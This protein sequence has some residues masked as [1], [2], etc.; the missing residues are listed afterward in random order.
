MAGIKTLKVQIDLL[1][2]SVGSSSA[3]VTSGFKSLTSGIGKVVAGFHTLKRIATSA[4]RAMNDSIDFV[5]VSNLFDVAF[6]KNTKS[7]N[8]FYAQAMKF[9]NQ[10]HEAFGTN[11]AETMKYQALFNQMSKSMGMTN[12][13]AYLLSE[14]FT[15]LGFD[16]SSLYN[17][18]TDEAMR[19]LRAGL[20]GQTKPLRD[21]GLDITQQS[22][23]PLVTE[24][25]IDKTV[26]S[27]SQAEKMALRYI[28]VIR[29]ASASH[30]DFSRTINTP[31]NQLKMLSANFAELRR[32]I[33]NLAYGFSKTL[34]PIINAVV[35]VLKILIEQIG[36][37]AGFKMEDNAWGVENLADEF[38]DAT[39][40]AKKLKN[41]T[42]GIDE[43]NVVSSND[44]GT[45]DSEYYTGGVDPRIAE[46]MKEY[47]NKM[48]EVRSK[49]VEIRDR[50]MEWLGYTKNVNEET[51][52]VTF[53]LNEGYQNIEKI[54][55]I[56]IVL[57]TLGLFSK[58]TEI[59]SAIKNSGI[60]KYFWTLGTAIVGSLGGDSE[61]FG[62]L[63][64]MLT[65]IMKTFGW[66]LLVI[67]VFLLFRVVSDIIK[68]GTMSL[69]DMGKMLIAIGITTLGIA[70]IF[71]GIPAL[72]TALVLS[73][74]MLVLTLVSK[75]DEIVTN[76]K[77]GFNNI[78]DF[79]TE[80][81]LNVFGWLGEAWLT[82]VGGLETNWKK[83]TN[84][85]GTIFEDMFLGIVKFAEDKI[86]PII[87]AIRSVAK[88]IDGLVGSDMASSIK[89]LN[90][91]DSIE[92]TNEAKQATREAELEAIEQKYEKLK[93]DWDNEIQSK[94]QKSQ[95]E[96]DKN[97]SG[98]YSDYLNKKQLTSGAGGGGGFRGG[99][100]EEENSSWLSS[101]SGQFT[102][103]S[104][105]FNTKLTETNETQA[106]ALEN[107]EALNDTLS[108]G[109]DNILSNL[110]IK[111][112]IAN[113][114][115]VAL[116][117][118]IT[119]MK[120]TLLVALK[121]VQTA[122]E[123]IKINITKNYYA[124]EAKGYAT[125]GFPNMGELFYA[126]ENGAEMVGKIG[127]K[128]AVVNNDQI[129]Q[130]VAEGVYKATVSAMAQQKERPIETTV[131]LNDREIA[132]AN[133]SGQKKL[134]YSLVGGAFGQG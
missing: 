73:V 48:A 74:G 54:R 98:I 34:L 128:T 30:G 113:E 37:F 6:E 47:D 50:I 71:G 124:G 38:D 105:V 18:S 56:I 114:N 78:G 59:I 4:S 26:K 19:K 55:D 76:I 110:A 103:L 88:I 125:G 35:M 7:A 66:V 122:C 119:K 85:I 133:N 123:N 82:V 10:L 57:L 16:L 23:Q 104:D 60:V 100:G 116:T 121:N 36:V 33:G 43:L 75:W 87:D 95:D 40:S 89:D 44:G 5:E 65:N 63:K 9:Q 27:L 42:L 134:G 11:L 29:Q 39:E 81:F 108:T 80:V 67:G 22:L 17:I 52:E 15:K 107:S 126:N 58:I 64:A 90:I 3:K 51:G 8:E 79:A 24:L 70:L 69:Q 2:N 72:I 120:D 45:N 106:K 92:E 97:V 77:V 99:S 41:I 131:I 118:E 1:G 94:I 14:N 132:R 130:A 13:Q 21:L 93:T 102:G 49:A 111:D 129:V 31:A 109:T 28:A 91:S 117:S 115:N 86:N 83:F 101:M 68:S 53:S 62:A 46:A 61:A 96:R 127:A 112:T 12:K 25:G 32:V 84:T 20:A